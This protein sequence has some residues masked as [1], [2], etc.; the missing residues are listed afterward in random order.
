[1]RGRNDRSP[2]QAFDHGD[3]GGRTS[4]ASASQRAR[5]QPTSTSR[6]NAVE[7][8]FPRTTRQRLRRAACHS[9]VSLLSRLPSGAHSPGT[10]PTRGGLTEPPP[11]APPPASSANRRTVQ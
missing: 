9:G 2:R 5:T 10:A 4:I 3:L 8:F 11:P 6:L 1:M 7:D